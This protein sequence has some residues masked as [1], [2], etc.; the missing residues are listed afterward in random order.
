MVPLIECHQKHADRRGRKLMALLRVRQVQR[1]TVVLAQ[2]MPVDLLA[3]IELD[4][5]PVELARD[6]GECRPLC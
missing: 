2:V 3:R 4:L 6:L 1:R 5:A